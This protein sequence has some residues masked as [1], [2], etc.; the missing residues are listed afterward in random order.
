MSQGLHL[1]QKLSLG[2]VLAPQLQQSLALLQAPSLE[3]RAL[4]DQELQQNPVLEEVPEMNEEDRNREESDTAEQL[5]LKEPPSD[6]N[7][8]PATEK[9]STEPVDDFQAEFEKLAQLDQDWRDSFSKTNLASKPSAEA[10]EKREFMFESLTA[11]KSMQESLLDQLRMADLDPGQMSIAEMIVGNIDDRGYLQQSLEDLAF[12][13]GVQRE[14]LL[15]ILR[16]IQGFHPP[17]IGSRNLQECLLLQLER[18]DRQHTIEYRIVR[19][20]MDAL[21]RRRL[22]E[23]ARAVNLSV[24][25]VQQAV[26]RIG[27]LNPHPGRALTS[28]T[29]QYIVTEVF[30]SMAGLVSTPTLADQVLARLDDCLPDDDDYIMGIAESAAAALKKE[31]DYETATQHLTR[32][33]ELPSLSTDQKAVVKEC[34][35]RV[36]RNV[37]AVTTNDEQLPHLR[38]SNT[39]KDIMA[40]PN[41]TETEREYIRERIRAGKFLIKSIHQRQATI[42]NIGNEIA[43]RQRKFLERGTAFLKPMTMVQVAEVVGVH[44]TTVS[45]AV[46]NKYI[47]TPQGMFEMKFFFT[48]GFTTED[49]VNMANTS[50]KELIVEII[51]GEPPQ[52]P[53]SDDHIVKLVAEKNIKLARRTVAKYRSEL[54]ILPSNLRRV[55]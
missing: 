39:Y 25:Q 26:E 15:E 8:D 16:I 34:L 35:L 52:S 38:I 17:G 24:D 41:S 37:P 23:I 49:G 40:N 6:L 14:A 20:H 53:Y 9:E 50:V 45:R 36:R 47:Q 2:L 27:H 21:G 43:K 55:Y 1:Q 22:P 48:S 10:E 18:H 32:L 11:D 13:T 4:I 42:L 28:E 12:T 19:D 5:D 31:Y 44:E 29:Q 54:N 33:S 30:I 7:Y 46:S 3:L 51:K